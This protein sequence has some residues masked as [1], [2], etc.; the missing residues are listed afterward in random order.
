MRAGIVEGLASPRPLIEG[1]PGIYQEDDLT[2]RW[3]AALD[4]VLAP[5]FLALDGLPGYLDPALTPD[6]F[7][8]WLAGWVGVLLDENWPIE[9]RRTFVAQAA[10]LYR[11]R[12][13]RA[14]L[15]AHVRIFS[16]GQVDIAD[17]GGVSWSTRSGSAFPGQPGYSMRVRV[18][19]TPASVDA[20]RLEALVASAK[21][22]HTVHSV[23]IA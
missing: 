11:L 6:D 10:E 1:L 7:L 4:E 2:R 18:R 23:E 22:A 13:T 8:E 16:G 5:V 12:G 3:M 14:G 9:R 15:A 20:G 19:G 17:S 21:P